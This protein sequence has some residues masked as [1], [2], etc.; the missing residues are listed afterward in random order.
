MLKFIKQYLFPAIGI[1]TLLG[2]VATLFWIISF[3]NEEN[4]KSL[5]LNQQLIEARTAKFD[6]ESYELIKEKIK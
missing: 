5:I 3:F 6:L 2:A 4:K 1:L